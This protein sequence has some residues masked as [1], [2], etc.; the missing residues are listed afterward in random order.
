MKGYSF[1]CQGESHKSTDKPCQDYSYHYIDDTISIA[2]VCDGHGGARYFRSDIGSRLCTEITAQA[3]KNFVANIDSSLFVGK[4]YI[5]VKAMSELKDA[6]DIT[7]TDNAFRQLFSSIVYTWYSEIE[8]YTEEHPVTDEER[9]K[10]E[11]KYIQSFERKD[12]LEKTYGC[13]LMAYVQT[14]GYWFAFHLG[15]GKCVSFQDKPLWT[16]P[17][18]WDDRCFLNKTTSICDSDA[19]NEFRYSYCGNGSFPI[20]VFLG[21]DGMDDSFGPMDNLVDFYMQVSKMLAKENEFE[22]QK[23][24]QETLPVLSKRGS[25]DDMSIAYVYDENRLKTFVKRIVRWQIKQLQEQIINANCKISDLNDII[26]SLQTATDS[27][28]LINL[29]YA[30]KDLTREQATLEKLKS[31]L[32]SREAELPSDTPSHQVPL[33]RKGTKSIMTLKDKMSKR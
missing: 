27:N 15:D 22:A 17:I 11:E 25:Q 18:P 13:T 7:P 31:K 3:I 14:S 29:D 24:I 8:K 10:V 12:S 23:S 2:I 9:S 1:S 6:E 26:C 16:E 19:L 4:P 21:S 33:H 30:R 5:K 32:Q 20:A 28:S